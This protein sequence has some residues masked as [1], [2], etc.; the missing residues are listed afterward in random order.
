M[1]CLLRKNAGK[2]LC[3]FFW[4]IAVFIGTGKP[5][6]LHAQ[7]SGIRPL[8]IVCK[9][10]PLPTGYVIVSVQY[11]QSCMGTGQNI[12]YTVSIPADGMTVCN[13]R[14]IPAPYV[15]TTNQQSNKCGG[16]FDESVIRTVADGMA[17]CG[18]GFSPIPDGFVVSSASNNDKVT[19]GDVPIYRV[20]PAGNG[21]AIC[22][23][24]VKPT[25]YVITTVTS[26]GQCLGSNAYVL[27]QFAP[28]ITACSFSPLPQGYVVTAGQATT[29]C[30]DGGLTGDYWTF[31]EAFSGMTVCP[32]SPIPASYFIT[33]QV[34]KTNCYGTNFGYVLTKF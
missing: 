7:D 31:S 1:D 9:D 26:S 27:Q 19:C 20:S 3:L 30:T 29:H 25:G 33:G 32:F 22:N 4:I 13:N 10:W 34:P 14:A 23:F 12:E 2:A 5:Q 11:S 8:D 24:S 16:L 21:V 15:I 6:V 28:G 17:V 18:N